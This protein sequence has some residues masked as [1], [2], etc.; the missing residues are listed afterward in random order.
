MADDKQVERLDETAV[1][2]SIDPQ[3]VFDT[4]HAYA[5]VVGST[6]ALV[7]EVKVG[8][9]SDA[10]EQAAPSEAKED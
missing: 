3:V 6:A 4:A 8:G 10:P 2:R 1:E 5:E 7:A 9:K